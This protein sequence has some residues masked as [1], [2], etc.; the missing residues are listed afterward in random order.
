MN[1]RFVGKNWSFDE[2]SGVVD[3][4][5]ADDAFEIRIKDQSEAEDPGR[6]LS[7]GWQW[8][9]A[10][11]VAVTSTGARHFVVELV[12]STTPVEVKLH[13]VL[14]GTPIMKRWLELTNTLPSNHWPLPSSH[15]GRESSGLKKPPSA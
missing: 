8:V 3:A 7:A 11:E 13:T 9:S 2:G 10:G 6:L 5:G 1:G 14:D 15:L 12:H 4:I